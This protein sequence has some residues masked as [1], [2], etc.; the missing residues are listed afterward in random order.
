MFLLCL[1]IFS[2]VHH[3]SLSLSFISQF[4]L[5]YIFFCCCDKM[6][7]RSNLRKRAHC[8]FWTLRARGHNVKYIMAS[9]MENW[10]ITCLNTRKHSE[11]TKSEEKLQT[12][13]HCPLV[14]LSLRILKILQLPKTVT[15]AGDQEFERKVSGHIAHSN[16]STSDS[17]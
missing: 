16:Q 10:V 13:K 6:L 8:D 11:W 17:C 4:S 14:T 7:I 9:G 2:N 3:L 1:I 12:L 15:Q 5:Y